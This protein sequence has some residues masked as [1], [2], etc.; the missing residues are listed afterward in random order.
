VAPIFAHDLLGWQG[1]TAPHKTAPPLTTPAMKGA[2]M[3]DL[4][5]NI[6]RHREDYAICRVTQPTDRALSNISWRAVIKR[7]QLY[8]ELARLRR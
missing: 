8:R 6:F 1:G 2:A 5:I 7:P 4:S 3:A